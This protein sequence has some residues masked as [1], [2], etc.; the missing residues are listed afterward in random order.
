M[1]AGTRVFHAIA[2]GHWSFGATVRVECSGD[3]SEALN[4][5]LEAMSAFDLLNLM[6]ADDF[7][8]EEITDFE[9]IARHTLEEENDRSK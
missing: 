3:A 1:A 5:K 8:V 6:E 4:V 2:T 7:E 9:G